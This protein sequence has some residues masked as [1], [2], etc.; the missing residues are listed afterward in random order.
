MIIK[1]LGP[2]DIEEVVL[3]YE[4]CFPDYFLTKLGRRF[5]RR[6]FVEYCI[7]DF[8]YG[9]VSRHPMTNRVTA[10]VVG[11]GHSEAHHRS[12]YRRN[13]LSLGPLILARFVGNAQLRKMI[14]ERVGHVFRHLIVSRSSGESADSATT[15]TKDRTARLICIAALPEYHGSGVA[16]EIGDRFEECLRHAGYKRLELSVRLSNARA[17]RF[18]QKSGWTVKTE[19]SGL[20]KFEKCLWTDSAGTS[21]NSL[22]NLDNDFCDTHDV[23][24]CSR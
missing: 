22:T 21:D 19:H 15:D 12:F 24:Q 20:L 23:Q 17:I 1:P 5:L 13:M 7:H 11:S 16:S 18:Y 6:Y 4:Q 14:W 9:L 2:S 3:I 10:F 8:D